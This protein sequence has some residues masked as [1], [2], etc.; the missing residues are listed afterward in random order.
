MI[1]SDTCFIKI[2]LSNI[3]YEIMLIEF[4][5]LIMVYIYHN[6]ITYYLKRISYLT[7]LIN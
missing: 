5:G 3:F 1:K 7:T 4:E 6:K 2:Y